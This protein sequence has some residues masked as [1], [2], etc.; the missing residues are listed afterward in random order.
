MQYTLAYFLCIFPPIVKTFDPV[1]FSAERGNKVTYF[2]LVA[3]ILN[4]TL[5]A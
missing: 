5:S 3:A 2:H 1:V 4:V